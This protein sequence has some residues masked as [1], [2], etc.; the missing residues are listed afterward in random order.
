MVEALLDTDS[1]VKMK[2]LYREKED[3]D[4]KLEYNY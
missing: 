2:H 4:S 1:Y 3:D